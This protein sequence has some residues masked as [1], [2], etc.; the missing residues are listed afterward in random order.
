[1]PNTIELAAITIAGA[2]LVLAPIDPQAIRDLNTPLPEPTPE[3]EPATVANYDC[4]GSL[5][6]YDTV[7][8]AESDIAQARANSLDIDEWHVIGRDGQPLRIVRT[9]DPGDTFLGGIDISVI[10]A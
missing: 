6:G 10:P 2:A 9:T 8:K 5:W 1:M 4:Y 3:P 7:T